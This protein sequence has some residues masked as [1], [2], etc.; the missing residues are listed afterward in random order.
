MLKVG[1]LAARAGLTVRTLHH[2]DSIKLLSP[3][4]RSDAGYRLYDRDDVARLQQIQALRAFGMALADIG[5]YLDSPDASPL[6]IVERQLSGLERQIAEAAHM[7]EQL[8]RLRSKLAAGEETDLSIWLTTLEQMTMYEKHF[9][10]EELARLPLYQNRAAQAEWQELVRHAQSLIERGVPPT[11]SE[12]GSFA[13]RWLACLERDSGGNPAFILRLTVMT[14]QDPEA[15]KEFGLTPAVLDYMRTAIAE[16]RFAIYARYLPLAAIE[17]MRRHE[18]SHSD[19][20]IVLATQVHACREAD[21]EAQSLKAQ[22]LARRWFMMF[23]D[24]VGDDPEVVS[25]FRLAASSEPLLHLGTGIG[26]EVLAFL[27]KA[28]AGMAMQPRKA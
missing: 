22:E 28:M 15:Q 27:R 20:W 24:M 11:S 25:Q 19:E 8:L 17:R 26:D 13:E 3:S 10:K 5:A 16:V 18:A 7:R 23:T 12:A 21:P 2:Y 4:A 6:A 1:E 14:G 9:S